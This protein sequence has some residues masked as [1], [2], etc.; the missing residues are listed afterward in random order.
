MDH[1]NRDASLYP[2]LDAELDIPKSMTLKYLMEYQSLENWV[3]FGVLACPGK[4]T[5]V[6]PA[7]ISV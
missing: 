2:L 5:A 6:T 7:A 1:R 4:H 3:L